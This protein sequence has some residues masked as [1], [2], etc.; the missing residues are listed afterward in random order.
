M[1]IDE[2]HAVARG[3]SAQHA[4]G[5][6][7]QLLERGQKL[8]LHEFGD[9]GKALRVG[10]ECG[11]NVEAGASAGAGRAIQ[12]RRV[13]VRRVDHAREVAA[14]ERFQRLPQFVEILRQFALQGGA[15]LVDRTE[16]AGAP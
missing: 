11:M 4:A 10:V 6:C 15:C 5:A 2:G 16:H 8:A 3:I 1:L 7:R 13:R 14:D 12:Q 9:L